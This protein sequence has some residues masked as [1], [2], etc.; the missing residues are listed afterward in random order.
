MSG[1]NLNKIL[2]PRAVDPVYNVSGDYELIS[3]SSPF[4][5]KF[6]S[7]T[8]GSITFYDNI[9]INVIVIG[10]GGGAPQSFGQAANG[11]TGAD[12]VIYIYF[13]YP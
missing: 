7:S 10:A 11:S 2:A 9:K 6:S 4:I 3:S 13:E 5:I 1:N 8:F 12:D